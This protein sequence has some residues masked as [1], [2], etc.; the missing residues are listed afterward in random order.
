MD[1]L[2]KIKERVETKDI[3]IGFAFLDGLLNSKW[4]IYKYGISI[5]RKLDDKIIDRIYSGPTIEYFHL[6]NNINTELNILSNEIAHFLNS[7]GITAKSIS[8]TVMEEELDDEYRENLRYSI[9]HKMLAT[10]AGL[11]WIGKTDLFVSSKFGPRVRLSSVLTTEK[12]G[13]IG[14][15]INESKCGKCNICVTKCPAKAASGKLWDTSVVRDEFYDPFKCREFARSIS[16]KNINKAISLC[17]I[18]VSVCPQGRKVKK[19]D[20]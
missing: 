13:E 14:N 11:G 18:C 9:S 17:G 20:K 6:Y 15:P 8:A 1:I 12:I 10:Q 4:Q 16:N 3:E 7:N 2:S 5:A 19:R